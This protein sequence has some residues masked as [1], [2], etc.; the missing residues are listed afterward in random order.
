MLKIIG[1]THPG[2]VRENNQDAYTFR[3]LSPACGY[4][5]VCDGMGGEKAGDIAS[6]TACQLLTRFFDRDLV[7]NMSEGAVKAVMFSAISAANTKVYSL[8]KEHKEYSGMGTTLSA[9][10]IMGEEM[11]LVNIGDS[12][13][14]IGDKHGAV[15]VTKDHTIVQAMVDRGE[16]TLEEA[17]N[18]PRRHLI[19]RAVGIG[20]TLDI[21][22]QMFRLEKGHKVLLCSDGLSNY[23][24][25]QTL[26]KLMKQAAKTG[27]A[28]GFIDHANQ[29]GGSDNVTA[30][31]AYQE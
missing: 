15:Q 9:A 30:I 19:T 20:D 14:Y 24:E 12:R 16:I 6:Q 28:K 23:A 18:H 1:A 17:K 8:S 21:D 3:L 10:I 13:I 7:E 31:M 26:A 29:M 5:V 25:E 27:S 22:Y 4:A 11:H 2:K